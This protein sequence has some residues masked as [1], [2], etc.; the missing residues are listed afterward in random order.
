M[1]INENDE[2]RIRK[3]VIEILDDILSSSSINI[4]D[5]DAGCYRNVVDYDEIMDKMKSYR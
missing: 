1:A 3:L 4:Y 2:D 5:N